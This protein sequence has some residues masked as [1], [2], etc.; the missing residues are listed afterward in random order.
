[1][2]L[3]VPFSNTTLS[4]AMGTESL[5]WDLSSCPWIA[6]LLVSFSWG[7]SSQ[8]QSRGRWNTACIRVLQRNR[9]N[10]MCV[11][12]KRYFEELAHTTV[13]IW[14]V[15]NLMWIGQEAGDSGKSYSSSPEAVCQEEPMCRWSPEVIC[16]RSHSCCVG[17]GCQP[18]ILFRSSI[19][20]MRPE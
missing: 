3:S 6:C 11:S 7:Q 1:M 5:C 20:Q 19:N 16:C 4:T 17:V 8:T 10:R 9:T 12:I 14:Q 2:G 15:Q 13:E 18:F